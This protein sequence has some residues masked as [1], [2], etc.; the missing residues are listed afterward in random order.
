MS[1]Q[2][3]INET[4]RQVEWALARLQTVQMLSKEQLQEQV[5]EPFHS[6]CQQLNSMGPES[7]AILR[8][9]L[10][11][12]HF[13]DFNRAQTSARILAALRFPEAIQVLLDAALSPDVMV[14]TRGQ[15]ALQYLSP[16][17]AAFHAISNTFSAPAVDEADQ[18]RRKQLIDA[19]GRQ[20][21]P[22]F[23]AAATLWMQNH[24]D[25]YV[26]RSLAMSLAIVGGSSATTI[27][28]T[29]L[30]D[31]DTIVKLRAAFGLILAAEQQ[32]LDILIG[33]I[34][35]K[36][37]PIRTEATTLLGLLTLP[38]VI[39]PVLHSLADA[40][41]A[42]RMAAIVRS[43]DVGVR[44]AL[45][46]LA[47]LL[48]DKNVQVA[49]Q[50]AALLQSLTGKTLPYQWKE[51]RLTAD[52]VNAVM[53]DCQQLYNTW[54][55]NIRYLHG[56]LLTLSRLA[57]ALL[58]G[59]A[60]AAFW[61]LVSMTGQHFGFDPRVDILVNYDAYQRWQLWAKEHDEEFRAG[62][63]Y[64]LGQERKVDDD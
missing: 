51:R 21:V 48:T 56:Q 1:S 23:F 6:A 15:R 30:N 47:D 38:T 28:Q 50:A 53:T 20:M 39:Q 59:F 52:S 10:F 17:E 4:I 37:A 14:M 32:H 35:A 40:S 45:I 62:Y 54:Q 26:R 22:E 18:Q 13:R 5:L 61:N 16:S 57:D 64:Y 27:L 49:E 33:A 24:P 34:R 46:H 12:T 29:A 2:I 9:V 44:E 31:R 3:D 63:W 11:S 36:S 41:T 19:L 43:H 25:V 42:V 7:V 60:T 8:A 55:P 58:S